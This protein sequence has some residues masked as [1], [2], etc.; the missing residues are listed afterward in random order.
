MQEIQLHHPT[1]QY[2]TEGDVEDMEKRTS[3]V[4]QCSNIL[5]LINIMK[6]YIS[7]RQRRGA[8]DSKQEMKVVKLFHSV[9]TWKFGGS[10]ASGI[11]HLAYVILHEPNKIRIF[12]NKTIFSVRS[13]IL[14]TTKYLSIAYLSYLEHLAS[15]ILVFFYYKNIF[16]RRKYHNGF[17]AKGSPATNAA[18]IPMHMD[19]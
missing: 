11:W 10:L 13:L 14:S 12:K 5:K 4:L 19:N 7:T 9:I 2:C 18:R 6:R 8:N 16:A 3:F 17:P 15:H 1:K